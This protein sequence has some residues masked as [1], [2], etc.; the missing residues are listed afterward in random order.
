MADLAFVGTS[1]KSAPAGTSAL[2]L[3]II[4]SFPTTANVGAKLIVDNENGTISQVG[5][6]V[7]IATTDD[8]ATGDTA[9]FTVPGPGKYAIAFRG[10][11]NSVDVDQSGVEVGFLI[12]T[13]VGVPLEDFGGPQTSTDAS[14]L[15][16]GTGFVRVS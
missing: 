6:G 9:S 16:H 1:L 13:D 10:Q 4:A 3:Q 7:V 11:A 15:V 12:S 8:P 14:A 2:H 5:D